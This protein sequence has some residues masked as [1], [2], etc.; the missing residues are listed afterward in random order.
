MARLGSVQGSQASHIEAPLRLASPARPQNSGNLNHCNGYAA[1]TTNI[2][3]SPNLQFFRYTPVCTLIL[4]AALVVQQV[5]DSLLHHPISAV[6]SPDQILGLDL[7]SVFD[8]LLTAPALGLSA[9]K[10]LRIAQDTSRVHELKHVH[11]DG[12]AWSIRVVPISRN[13]SMLYYQIELM[14]ITEEHQ[15]QLEMEE[16]LY[17]NETFRILVETVK[18]YA[19]FMLDPTGHIA[20]W[21]AGAQRFK[22]YKREEIIGKHFSS[23][24]SQEDKDNDK[25]GREL[26]DALRDGR[27][28]DE[29]WRYRKDGSSFWANVVIT[30]VYRGDT[31][32]GFS[33]VTRDLTERR[34]A[35][36]QLI[37]AYEEASKLKSEF[38]ANMSH[39]IRTPMHGMLSALTLL[40][41]TKLNPDQLELAHVIEESGEIL[42]Q[43]I[44]DILDYSKLASG[45]F[46]ISND[47][48]NITEI[49]QSIFRALEK[50]KPGIELLNEIDPK[51]PKAA[52]GDSLRYRQIVQNL[53]SNATKFTEQGSVRLRVTLQD[54]DAEYYTILTE[55]IDTGIGVPQEVS[56]SL[57]TPFM[58]FDNS[59]TKRFKGTG[60]GLSICKSLAE[61]MGGK[62]GFYANPAGQGS[63]F[64]FTARMK[65]VDQL[66]TMDE[67]Q[68]EIEAL[69][70]R[71]SLSPLDDIR[72]AAVD[73]RVLLAEDNPI[74][75]KIMVKMLT[76]LGFTQIDLAQ[77]GQ[78]AVTIAKKEAPYDLILMDINMPIQDGVAATK[79]IRTAGIK[80]P[81]I[82]MTANALKGQA[83]AYMAKGMNGYVAKPVDRKLLVKVLLTWL[84]PTSPPD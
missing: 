68:Q 76:S 81:I 10:A 64:W 65:K 75:Q 11:I 35:E 47:I 36:V 66:K 24:Y 72:K 51:L 77:D 26:A 6:R 31:L 53:M 39:E 83:E 50:T 25:P 42:L 45:C 2:N 27:C 57:F 32:L 48:I 69:A 34:S 17:T 23:F 61:L 59:A 16:R 67:L 19:I 21:N 44:N 4:D 5:S 20:T 46:S 1:T 55:V 60:L 74:N 70:L 28:E 78:E 9:R 62:I 3:G 37:A 18:D 15:K 52:E 49:V 33:K 58:Q 54:Q 8:T 12:T 79:D 30:P 41:D 22:G 43:V 7:D 82:A 29:G 84:N 14:D 13:G 71:T 38:L 40:L 63:V 56:G 80:T 73:R